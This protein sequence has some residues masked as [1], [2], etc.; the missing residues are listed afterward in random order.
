MSTAGLDARIVLQRQ[1]GFAID[2]VISIQPG[3]TVA[4]LGP[5]G[6]GKSTIVDAVAGLLPID[7]GRIS[8][9]DRVFDDPAAGVFVEPESRRIGTVFQD[10]AL[11]P[12]LSV[13]ENVAFGLRSSG[14]GR[15]EARARAREW[16][17]SMDLEGIGQRTPDQISGGQAQRVALARSLITE[18][19]L[20]LLDEPLAA[21]DV[22]SRTGLRRAL[23]GHLETFHGPR[24]LITHDP[25]EAFLLADEIHVIESGRS[26]QSGSADDLRLRPRTGYAA[27]LVGVNLFVGEAADGV[28]TVDGHRLQIGDS[29]LRGPAVVTIHPRAVAV[30]RDRPSGSPRNAWSTPISHVE[31]MGDRVRV[32]FSGPMPITAEVTSEAVDALGMKRGETMWVSIKATEIVARAD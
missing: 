31:R 26:S 7:D 13:I 11:F 4:L 29:A 22:S 30:H 28:V 3:A 24:L 16:L 20:L 19:D 6:A 5:N 27:D 10:Y 12:H 15:V 23:A 18:P 14:V 8:L 9:G 25:S 1:S 2:V 21:I 17:R 32:R